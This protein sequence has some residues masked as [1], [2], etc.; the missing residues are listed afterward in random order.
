MLYELVIVDKAVILEL[1]E[2]SPEK[3]MEFFLWV[4]SGTFI[5]TKRIQSPFAKPK[6][7]SSSL[8]DTSL[9]FGRGRD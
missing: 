8:G 9:T 7:S 1:I 6:A 3:D 5:P 2:F 4:D